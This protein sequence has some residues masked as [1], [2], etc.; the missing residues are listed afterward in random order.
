MVAVFF[1]NPYAAA[2]VP[3]VPAMLLTYDF[4]D[5]AEPARCARSPA[6]CRSSA[7]CRS[8]SPACSRSG[9]A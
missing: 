7:S 5:L 3:D 9:T 2:G 8:R 4:S 1:G 6:R